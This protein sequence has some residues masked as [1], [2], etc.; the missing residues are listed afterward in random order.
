M[1]DLF[2]WQT[3]VCATFEDRVS[4]RNVRETL[5]TARIHIT[6]KHVVCARGTAAAISQQAKEGTVL[7]P[8]WTTMAV[9]SLEEPSNLRQPTTCPEVLQ[10]TYMNM[11]SETTRVPGRTPMVAN[12]SAPGVPSN[13]SNCVATSVVQPNRSSPRRRAFHVR[14]DTGC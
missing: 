2:E 7:Q 14:L 11:S 13:E 9:K 6:W 8:W 4:W 12:Q 10:S 3:C 5:D 1:L